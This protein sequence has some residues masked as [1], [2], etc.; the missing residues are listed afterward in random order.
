MKSTAFRRDMEYIFENADL[1]IN[2]NIVFNLRISEKW[3]K[4]EAG[5]LDLNIRARRILAENQIKTFEDIMNNWPSFGN[6]A[7]CG[8]TTAKEVKNALIAYYYDGLNADE[9]TQ[10]W[11]DALGKYANKKKEIIKWQ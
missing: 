6:F 5:M 3:K 8:V 10:F 2:G 11:I 1:S 7:G 9:R 4:T